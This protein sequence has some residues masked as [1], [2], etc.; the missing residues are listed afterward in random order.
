MYYSITDIIALAAL[1]IW[2]AIPL[3]WIPVHCMP[4]FF[5]RLGYLTYILPFVTWLPAAYFIYRYRDFLLRS[6]VD[7]PMGVNIVGGAVLVA[8]LALQTWTLLLLTLPGIMGVPEVNRQMKSRLVMHGPFSVVRHPTYLSHTLML[9][10]VFL[11]TEVV[12][13]G[14]VTLLDGLI[15]N[16]MV[17]PLEE[18]E[19]ASRFGKEY[20]EYRRKVQQRFFPKMKI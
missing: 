5:G 20:D 14:I 10:G 3:F 18:R 9:L 13:I 6:T 4:R 17:I 2:P 11:L 12:A 7:L 15:V 1:I 19:L 16:I 8:G